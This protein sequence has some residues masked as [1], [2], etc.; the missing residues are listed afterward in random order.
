MFGPQKKIVWTAKE[1][2]EVRAVQEA[3]AQKARRDIA[4]WETPLFENDIV[5]ALP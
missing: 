5:E 3:I 4:D 2:A 1:I